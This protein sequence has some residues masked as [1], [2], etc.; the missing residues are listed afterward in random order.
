MAG[1]DNFYD[2]TEKKYTQVVEL[3]QFSNINT[4]TVKYQNDV[5]ES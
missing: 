2:I 4:T 1:H 3:G 5:R